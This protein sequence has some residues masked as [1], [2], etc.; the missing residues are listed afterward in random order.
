MLRYPQLR[1]LTSHPFICWRCV[2][3]LQ[4]YPFIR[5]GRND[6]KRTLGRHQ[7][8]KRHFGNRLLS[9]AAAEGDSIANNQAISPTEVLPS[10][11]DI[12]QRLRKWEAQNA[13]QFVLPP[14]LEELVSP[15]EVQNNLTRPME[16]QL[17][18]DSN[19][20]YEL[21]DAKVDQDGLVDVGIQRKFLRPG[22][23]VE[24]SSYGGLHQDLAVYIRDLET[25]SQFYTMS[26][27]WLHRQSQD[28]QFYVPGFIDSQELQNLL[29]YL[30]T[31]DVPETMQ[32]IPHIFPQSIPRE[33]GKPLIQKMLDFWNQSESTYQGAASILDDAHRRIA[34]KDRV[35]YA[36]LNEIA[37]KLLLRQKFGNMDGTF[38]KST[39]Y[40]VHRSLLRGDIGFRSQTKGT[41]RAG[42]HYEIR[43]RK[44]TVNIT[45]VKKAVRNYQE[46]EATKT[47]EAKS[48]QGI[49]IRRFIYKAR[50]LID[51][52]RKTRQL[53]AQ[54]TIGPSSITSPDG[55]SIKQGVSRFKFNHDDLSVIGFLESWAALDSFAL[56]SS[57]NGIGPAI[58]RATERYEHMHLGP[59]TAWTFLQEI[60][61]IAPWENR[62][63]FELR[64]KCGRFLS[65]DK[66]STTEGGFT[67]DK[68]ESYRKD[69]G[70]LAVYCID[71]SNAHEIDDGISIEPTNTPGEFWIHVHTADPAAHID[72]EGTV[73]KYAQ[74]LIGNVY[75]PEN[76]VSML[77]PSYVEAHLSLAPNRPCLTFSAR[78]NMNGEILQYDITPG[79]IHN[80]LFMN[81]SVI[82]EVVSNTKRSQSKQVTYRV[83]ADITIQPPSRPMTQSDQI[84]DTN[85]DELRLLYCIA[86]ARDERLTARGGIIHANPETS[87]SV[88]FKGS[89][90]SI[91]HIAPSG[92]ESTSSSFSHPG[93]PTVQIC[94]DKVDLTSKYA[95][96]YQGNLVRT[97]MLVA[98]EVAARWCSERGIPIPFR[99]TPHN[100]ESVNPL[101]FFQ[102]N[103][104][105]TMDEEGNPDNNQLTAYFKMLGV[106]PSLVSGPHAGIGV[107]M[108]AK[109][110]SPLR[111][112]GD[113]L[114]HWQVEAALLEEARTG[115]SL[116][117]NTKDDFLPFSRDQVEAILPH[118]DT[119]ERLISYGMRQSERHWLCHFLVRAW[120]FNETQI[121]STLPFIVERVDSS[122]GQVYGSLPTFLAR[123]KS[124]S[125]LPDGLTLG[126]LKSGD[127]LEV[128]LED[129]N[130]FSRSIGVKVLGRS[131]IEKAYTKDQ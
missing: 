1:R 74:S 12:R 21:G 95:P 86:K 29:P 89:S 20:E 11:L 121:P 76:I 122:T 57:L 119:R 118:L 8:S 91:Q 31:T 51:E 56:H 85:R 9:H 131:N 38:P 123:A 60:G 63:A 79:R 28:A 124:M 33:L 13:A 58:L 117:D 73:G 81:P 114:L 112:F 35:I 4:S 127:K 108:M 15:G 102:R 37:D 53:T 55:E 10:N 50:F 64:L 72:P 99:V 32:N 106:Q 84:S 97:F 14:E 126:E 54:G 40:A 116:V 52:S 6:I 18:I 36:T 90:S 125:T 30:P 105:P 27:K 128:E 115:R 16:G 49:L 92:L 45:K 88:F 77:P 71:E 43:P 110:T 62:A 22:D 66:G 80:V 96:S 113:L 78:M 41:L 26:G 47:S 100:P 19:E 107:D 61:V 67:N 48:D 25:Q 69:W 129:V 93:D 39:L 83:G 87:T 70:Q 2:S 130:V 24:L 44:E 68:I 111:R 17:K 34:E 7:F 5:K 103:V 23:L 65:E 104:L 82:N 109:C 94:V 75:M 120:L 101:E 3:K 46:S 98:G 42:G 59:S